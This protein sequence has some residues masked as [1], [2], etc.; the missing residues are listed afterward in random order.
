MHVVYVSLVIRWQTSLSLLLKLHCRS[1]ASLQCIQ[2]ITQEIN[3]FQ[4]RQLS[5]FRNREY[6][7]HGQIQIAGRM[8]AQFPTQCRSHLVHN[9]SQS[10][11]QI[12][13]L[14]TGKRA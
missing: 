8:L 5:R 12:Y 14:V 2:Q 7:L 9:F 10:D 11:R 13:C 3:G 1:K 4:M 6:C